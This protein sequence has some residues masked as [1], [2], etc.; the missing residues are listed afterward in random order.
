[1]ANK[2]LLE[3]SLMAFINKDESTAQKL[4]RSFFIETAREQ[5]KKLSESAEFGEPD[6]TDDLKDDTEYA[7]DEEFGLGDEDE[8]TDSED[9]TDGE[10]SPEG[11]SDEP[12]EKPFGEEGEEFES[13]EDGGVD[14]ESESMP[15]PEEWNEIETAFD[16]LKSLFD[17]LGIDSDD[18]ADDE[19]EPKDGEDESEEEADEL[20][21][22]EP[23][24]HPFQ[25]SEES[26]EEDEDEQLDEDYE[27]VQA[28]AMKD[29]AK[30]K[31]PVAS[32]AKA[33]VKGV[34]PVQI[35]SKEVEMSNP[36]VSEEDYDRTGKGADDFYD[37]SS[38]K[39]ASKDTNNSAS[40][41]RPLKK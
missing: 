33:P 21:F 8:D 35:K 23:E 13:D 18:D 28:P 15:N 10:F 1:M 6:M 38:E 22:D 14:E 16:E 29:A 30:S 5:D 31:S 34:S 12:V 26:D 39:G 17:E 19:F 3:K 24:D 9:H 36:S 27:Q 4:L 20:A 37:K 41:V 7:L 32:N 2:K 40:V 25:E 11:S